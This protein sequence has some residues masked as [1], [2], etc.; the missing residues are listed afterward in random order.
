MA[1]LNI[2]APLTWPVGRRRRRRCCCQC[3]FVSAW[4]GHCGRRKTHCNVYLGWQGRGCPRLYDRRPSA[5]ST[6]YKRFASWSAAGDML[7][8]AG[9]M[10]VVVCV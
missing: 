9:A 4:T 6:K 5:P 3:R 8:A 2:V 10:A 7:A 1:L